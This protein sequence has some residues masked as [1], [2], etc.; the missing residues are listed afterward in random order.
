MNSFCMQ[1]DVGWA[2]TIKMWTIN[3]FDPSQ[4]D[5][6]K[7]ETAECGGGKLEKLNFKK[8]R[9]NVLVYTVYISIV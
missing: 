4:P 7:L 3:R 5:F 9:N 1:E 8:V 2:W 6:W